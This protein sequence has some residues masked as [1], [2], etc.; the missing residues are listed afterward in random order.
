MLSSCFQKNSCDEPFK[1]SGSV[2]VETAG[3]VNFYTPI[4]HT[5]GDVGDW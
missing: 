1:M 4:S 3:A 2:K 5:A